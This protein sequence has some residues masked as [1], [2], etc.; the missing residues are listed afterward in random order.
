MA[1]PAHRP[2]KL[3]DKLE[4]LSQ[5]VYGRSRVGSITLDLCVSCG[6]PAKDFRDK[7]STVEYPMSGLCQ[8]CQ[9]VEFGV[10]D[11]DAEV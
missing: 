10:N 1:V 5:Q 2:P 11:A 9:D 8:Q 7:V 4:E 3:V 6:G